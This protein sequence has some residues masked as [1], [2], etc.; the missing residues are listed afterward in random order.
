MRV[1]TFSIVSMVAASATALLNGR[2]KS[3]YNLKPFTL[4]LEN[5]VPRML[6]LIRNTQLPATPEYPD[7]TFDA[8]IPLSTLKSLRTEWLTQFDWKREQTAINR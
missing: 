4:N 7:L 3:G 1:N 8:G 6:E 2:S 5:Q